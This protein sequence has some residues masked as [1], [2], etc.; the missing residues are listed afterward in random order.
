M[1]GSTGG[2]ALAL[3]LLLAP[4]CNR[5]LPPDVVRRNG[6]YVRAEIEPVRG[7]LALPN[8]RGSV[9]FAVIGDSGRGDRAQ[10][11]VAAQMIAWREKF[12]YD[13]VLMLGDNIY[14]RHTPADYVAKFEEPYRALLD[15]GVTFQAAIGNHDDPAQI[16]YEKFNMDGERYH[17]FRRAEM[18]LQGGL[19]GAGVRFFVLD[20]RSFDSQQ[21]AWLRAQL[22]D[23][24]SRWKIAYFHHP[25]YTSGR[26]QSASRILRAAVEPVLVSGDVDVVFAGHEHVYERI[27]PQKGIVYF[28]VGASGAIRKGDIRPSA[29]TA[30]AFDRDN[31]FLLVEIAGDRLHFQAISREGATVD[32]G[33][34]RKE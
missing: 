2:L 14:D 28:T 19:T 30:R 25:L 16:Y 18:N 20:S 6:V 32:A 4:G 10:H 21:L 5:E 24:G 12:E 31:S 26:Y 7:A 1:R 9:K 8:K 13:L 27:A 17:S 23:S 15:D 34:I 3:A 33:V 29:L 11:E 22:S